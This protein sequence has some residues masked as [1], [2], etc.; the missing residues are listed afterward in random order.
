MFS[1]SLLAQESQDK[2]VF[3]P[4]HQIGISINHV[5]VFEGRDDEGNREVLTL[6]AWGL[7]Y[8]YHISKNGP[9]DCILI[10]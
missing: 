2:E 5:H 3:K 6:P 10:L 7:D 9:L 1:A 4:H 8:T